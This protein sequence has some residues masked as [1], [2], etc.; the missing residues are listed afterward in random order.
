MEFT[1]VETE[2]VERTGMKRLKKFDD[3]DEVD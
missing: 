2:G 1:A 3:G